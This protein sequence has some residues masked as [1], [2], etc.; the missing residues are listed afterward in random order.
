MAM[1]GDVVEEDVAGRHVAV[2]AAVID[3]DESLR[4]RP[5]LV[6]M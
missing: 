1:I 5:R 2:A 6:A 4:A 3:R